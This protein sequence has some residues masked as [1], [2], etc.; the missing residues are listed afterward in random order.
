MKWIT[1]QVQVDVKPNINEVTPD[2]VAKQYA[3]ADK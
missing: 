3:A 2:A 1:G